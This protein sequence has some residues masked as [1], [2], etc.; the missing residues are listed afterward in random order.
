MARKTACP[1]NLSFSRGVP[2]RQ[3]MSKNVFFARGSRQGNARR[4]TASQ[5]IV[6]IDLFLLFILIT[7]RTRATGHNCFIH[8]L[9][10]FRTIFYRVFGASAQ[11]QNKRNCAHRVSPCFA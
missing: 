7:R 3:K 4:Q 11:L 1:H 10:A 6:P 2:S 5:L 8:V 9:F